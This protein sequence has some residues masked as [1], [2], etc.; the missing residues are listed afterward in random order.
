MLDGVGFL[1]T[2]AMVLVPG[3]L[4]LNNYRTYCMPDSVLISSCVSSHLLLTTSLRAGYHFTDVGTEAQ[5][6]YKIAQGCRATEAGKPYFAL[7][8]FA[9]G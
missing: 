5:R 1:T 2:K 3:K 9:L 4:T 6:G 7:G 8:W